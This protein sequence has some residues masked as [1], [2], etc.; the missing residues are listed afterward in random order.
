MLTAIKKWY[1][2]KSH[3]FVSTE[4][5][6]TE[7]PGRRAMAGPDALDLN[8]LHIPQHPTG[9]QVIPFHMTSQSLVPEIRGPEDRKR[10]GSLRELHLAAFKSITGIDPRTTKVK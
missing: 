3:F 10:I 9:V 1:D 6:V 5:D 8:L 7:R 2:I 4:V